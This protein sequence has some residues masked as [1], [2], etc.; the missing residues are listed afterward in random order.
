MIARDVIKA[1]ITDLAEIVNFEKEVLNRLEYTSVHVL[2]RI[3]KSKTA[4]VL[5]IKDKGTIC[6]YAIGSL[7]FFKKPSGYIYKIAVKESM[8]R[9]GLASHILNSLEDFFVKNSME[10][11]FVDVRESNK[12]S[13]ALFR[14]NGYETVKKPSFY[15]SS[16]EGW[17][18]EKGVKF[19]KVLNCRNSD[20]AK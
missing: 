2:R 4:E 10:K 11:S 16:D 1:D 3:I 9:N 14:K 15:F 7:R 6:A 5:I 8:R 17:E 12:S 19:S 13:L 20:T 18:L